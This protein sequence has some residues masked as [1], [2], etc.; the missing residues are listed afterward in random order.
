MK[1]IFFSREN[2]EEKQCSNLFRDVLALLLRHILTA[3]LGNLKGVM[4]Q[5]LSD[6]PEMRWECLS[7]LFT[8]FRSSIAR[9]STI[10]GVLRQSF[11]AH[12]FI[13]GGALLLVF[14]LTFLQ[15]IISTQ[16]LK[17]VWGGMNQWKN[18]IS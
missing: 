14:C 8:L 16:Q 4:M 9:R 1:D 18:E 2:L 12:F 10:A 6:L 13:G 5:M 3:L 11:L 7:D 15:Q 17:G